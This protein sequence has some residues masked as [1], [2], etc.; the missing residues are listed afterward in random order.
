MFVTS[1]SLFL[2]WFI[3]VRNLQNYCVNF[4]TVVQVVVVKI[5]VT[6]L[7][8]RSMHRGAYGV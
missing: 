7:P 5:H 4:K 6:V 2:E 1:C 3:I 8:N